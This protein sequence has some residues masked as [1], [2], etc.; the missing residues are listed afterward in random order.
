MAPER[1]NISPA[2]G[3]A[4]GSQ[5]GLLP[6]KDTPGV[7][8]S[9]TATLSDLRPHRGDKPVFLYF[10]DVLEEDL[11]RAATFTTKGE[12][13]RLLQECLKVDEES[14]FRTEIL[15]DMH[16]HNYTFCKS[17]DFPPAKTSTLLSIMKVVLEESRSQRLTASA[18]FDVF[19]DLVLKHSVERPPRSVGVFSFDDVRAIMDY[20]HNGFFRHYRLYMYA[21]RTHCTLSF[22]LDND[23]M[24]I[25]P[26]APRPL[27]MKQS[28]EVEAKAQLELAEIFR[29]TE[30]ELAEEEA[31]RLWEASQ[32]PEDRAA[33]IKR[34]V[35]EGVKKLVQEFEG[36]L[37]DQDER[38]KDV[39][40]A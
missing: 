12:V 10:T 37:K 7:P 26:L 6:M 18:S 9:F 38:F 20:I 3:A 31:R 34:K 19:K 17:R 25:A 16:F 13:K 24:D 39:L 15:A 5:K 1:P 14:G 32:P 21:F 28:D 36:K 8:N 27:V 11:Q 2:L 22:L 33:M 35:D 4:L 29:P 40:Q 30:S 23:V